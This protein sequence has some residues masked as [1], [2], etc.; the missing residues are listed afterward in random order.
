MFHAHRLI[1]SKPKQNASCCQW[2]Y[3]CAAILSALDIEL[4]RYTVEIA[5]C[6]EFSDTGLGY[7]KDRY[8]QKSFPIVDPLALDLAA[9]ASQAYVKRVFSVCGDMCVGKRNRLSV[10]LEQRIFLRMKK[11]YLGQV[12]W[13]T[14][15]DVRE[16]WYWTWAIHCGCEWRCDLVLLRHH[17]TIVTIFECLYFCLLILVNYN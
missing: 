17:L 12:G 2:W 16:G 3:C 4:E 1:L 14:K 8:R 9:P 10:S 13:C 7:W 6:K 5:N 11:K 15:V